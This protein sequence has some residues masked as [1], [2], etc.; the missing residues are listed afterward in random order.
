MACPN[1]A[2]SL[3]GSRGVCCDILAVD[4]LGTGSGWQ[5]STGHCVHVASFRELSACIHVSTMFPACEVQVGLLRLRRPF[6]S[7]FRFLHASSLLLQEKGLRCRNS[8]TCTL[9]QNGYGELFTSGCYWRRLR[10]TA[11]G[12]TPLE[13]VL[14]ACIRAPLRGACG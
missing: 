1:Q 2:G 4:D 6:L 7:W 10:K 11:E 5:R 3:Q 8:P 13:N 9:S 14:K 12:A